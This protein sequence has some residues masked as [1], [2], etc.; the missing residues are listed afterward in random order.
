MNPI[1][2]II[3]GYDKKCDNRKYLNK[4][5]I[6]AFL[7]FKKVFLQKVVLHFSLQFTKIK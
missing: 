4:N 3:S 5:Y 7:Q 2:F 6:N 1:A